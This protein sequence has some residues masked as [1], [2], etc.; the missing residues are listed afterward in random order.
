MEDTD[1]FLSADD[2]L[3]V[4]DITPSVVE[5]EVPEWSKN[6]KPGKLRFR[7]MTASE[8]VRFQNTLGSKENKNKAWVRIFALCAVDKNGDRLF[9]D[10][11][12][13]D[14]ME[15]NTGVF[16]RL[17]TQLMSL[18][19]FDEAAKAAAKND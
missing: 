7:P 1:Q 12:M 15:K 16:M 10:A 13:S 17:Q 5:V 2:I 8:A 4:D 18:N 11:R 6:G 9:S 3:G 14:L 19:G